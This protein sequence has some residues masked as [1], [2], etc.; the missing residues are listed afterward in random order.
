LDNKETV[1]V[2]KD[3]GKVYKGVMSSM[4]NFYCGENLRDDSNSVIIKERLFRK[5]TFYELSHN[6]LINFNMPGN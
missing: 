2:H 6:L 1:M 3:F 5:P 4:D